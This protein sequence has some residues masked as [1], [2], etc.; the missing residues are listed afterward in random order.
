MSEHQIKS[1]QAKT[2]SQAVANHIILKKNNGKKPQKLPQIQYKLSIGEAGDKYEEE[3]DQ[4]ASQVMRMPKTHLNG[5]TSENVEMLQRRPSINHVFKQSELRIQRSLLS[6]VMQAIWESGNKKAFFNSLRFLGSPDLD[7]IL[8][9]S[10]NLRGDDLWLASNI[11]IYGRESGW[12]IHLKIE[13]EMK[14]WSDCGGVTEVHNILRAANGSQAFN[15]NVLLAII[16]E[17]AAASKYERWLAIQL[18]NYGPEPNFPMHIGIM[19]FFYKKGE[20]GV[21]ETLN[22][23]GYTVMTFTG[24]FDTWKYDVDGRIE[25]VDLSSRLR[26]STDRISLTIMLNAGLSNESAAMTLHHELGHVTSREPNRL[27]QEIQVRIQSE[28]FAIKHGLPP[29]G[30][31]YRKPNGTVNIP[32][33]RTAIF[34]SKHYNPT[35][36]TWLKRRYEGEA[37]IGPWV[38]PS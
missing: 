25:V 13:R 33:I 26:G 6:D 5:Q 18:M 3:A 22:N 31:N 32:A 11:V 34:R 19:N 30:R 17:L 7:L 15:S 2:E 14:G 20:E 4:V 23:N 16:I 10:K 37:V 21:I 24:A 36:K 27:V 28:Q 1:N 8:Y 12:P 29:T 35:D 9:I 38:L